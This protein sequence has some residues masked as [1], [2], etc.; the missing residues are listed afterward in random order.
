MREAPSRVVINGL[1]ARGATV[2]AYDPAAIDEAKHVMAGEKG[3]SYAAS[4][5]DALDDADALII[6]TE[7]KEFRSPDFDALK[8]RLKQPVV[9]DGRNLYDPRVMNESGIEYLS[10]GRP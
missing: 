4:P 7:W 10:V 5:V 2:S 1:L 8:S 9:I 3:I 6:V